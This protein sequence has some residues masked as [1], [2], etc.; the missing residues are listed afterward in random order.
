MSIIGLS[1]RGTEFRAAI[2]GAITEGFS[3]NKTIQ[4]LKDTYGRA[5][6]RTTF[7][8]DYRLLSG[9]KD[10]FEPMKSVRKDYKPSHGLYTETTI[11]HERK[12]AT[13]VDYTFESRK[14]KGLQRSH[15]TLRHDTS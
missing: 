3:A 14:V 15:Y 11:T 5:Y 8:S 7:L 2:K 1:K 4:L 10:V 6:Q 9:A 13:V 12:Y